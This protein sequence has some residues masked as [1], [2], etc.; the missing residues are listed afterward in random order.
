MTIIRTCAACG[1]SLPKGKKSHAQ[2]CNKACKSLGQSH[3][4]LKTSRNIS[5]GECQWCGKIIINRNAKAIYCSEYC[6]NTAKRVRRRKESL[7]IAK[8]GRVCQRCHGFIPLEKNLRTKYCSTRCQIGINLFYRLIFQP[9]K[10]H[11][12]GDLFESLVPAIAKF[13]PFCRRLDNDHYRRC[14]K[15]GLPYDWKVKTDIVLEEEGYICHVC[16]QLA[17]KELRGTTEPLAPELDHII[18]LS[19]P[20]SLGHIRANVACIHRKCNYQKYLAN[21]I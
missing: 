20:R 9:C 6:N 4:H 10:C 21:K 1:Q 19:D 5:L 18:E 16:K 12:C 14:L 11:R 13:C 3:R 8:T 17:P 7:K 2:Y 15:Y